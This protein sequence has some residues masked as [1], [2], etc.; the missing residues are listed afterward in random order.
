MSRSFGKLPTKKSGGKFIITDKGFYYVPSDYGNMVK[1]PHNKILNC[2]G[3]EKF[4]HIYKNG[5]QSPYLFAMT[6]GNIKINLL[7]LDVLRNN[8]N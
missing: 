7:G 5:R 3:D 2:G 1:I 4:L 6:L 8:A